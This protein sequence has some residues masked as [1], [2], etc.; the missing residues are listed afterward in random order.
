MFKNNNNKHITNELEMRVLDSFALFVCVT[1]HA[2]IETVLQ[3]RRGKE[4]NKKQ[5]VLR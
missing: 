4:F 1:S 2:F 3:G 5:L